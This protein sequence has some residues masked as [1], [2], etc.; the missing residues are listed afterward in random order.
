MNGIVIDVLFSRRQATVGTEIDAGLATVFS[1]VTTSDFHTFVDFF[2]DGLIL[3]FIFFFIDGNV[4]FYI[5]SIV[6]GVVLV[7]TEEA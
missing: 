6:Y 3:F 1:T 7:M 2:I 4:L 5:N